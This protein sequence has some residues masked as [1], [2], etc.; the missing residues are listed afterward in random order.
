M[1]FLEALHDHW[2]TEH[3]LLVPLSDHTVLSFLKLSLKKI[4]HVPNTNKRRGHI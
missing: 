3:V 2:L 4:L 1:C